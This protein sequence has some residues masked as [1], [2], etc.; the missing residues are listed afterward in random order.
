LKIDFKSLARPKL[1]RQ[2]ATSYL[3][4]KDHNRKYSAWSC[5][6]TVQYV[7]FWEQHHRP[8][9]Q[10]LSSSPPPWRMSVSQIVWLNRGV[11]RFWVAPCLFWEFYF[12]HRIASQ[13][14]HRSG[15]VFCTKTPERKSI[16]CLPLRLQLSL[17]IHIAPKRLDDRRDL[18]LS[19]GRWLRR[20]YL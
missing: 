20:Y 6:Q 17:L 7:Y 11:S 10:N 1:I 19:L 4:N 14:L 15:V 3:R 5:I 12:S 16:L 13:R 8:T 9:V 2:T 18:C